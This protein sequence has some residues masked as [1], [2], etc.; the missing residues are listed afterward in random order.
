ME[1]FSEWISLRGWSWFFLTYPH[2]FLRGL[3]FRSPV[4]GLLLWSEAI[5]KFYH[6]DRHRKSEY[7]VWYSWIWKWSIAVF[8]QKS[9]RDRLCFHNSMWSSL[10]MRGICHYL[11]A[12][13]T[14]RK[15]YTYAM[16]LCM[17]T[18]RCNIIIT[19]SMLL[20]IWTDVVHL[21]FVFTWTDLW[22]HIFPKGWGNQQRCENGVQ[23][24]ES[25]VGAEGQHRIHSELFWFFFAASWP[26]DWSPAVKH[27]SCFF[28]S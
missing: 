22:A 20:Y 7:H 18:Y 16:I 27:G 4:Q 11:M 26:L 14:C 13:G 9:E 17:H 24:Q 25:G 23:V 1:P 8:P 2:I 3:A 10:P 21:F 6:Q 28:R 19:S 12:R 5:H 15:L